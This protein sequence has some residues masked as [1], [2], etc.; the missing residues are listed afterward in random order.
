MHKRVDDESRLRRAVRVAK[1][2]TAALLIGTMIMTAAPS[3]AFAR[4]DDSMVEKQVPKEEGKARIW[5]DKKMEVDAAKKAYNNA[6]DIIK[7]L[8]NKEAR[9]DE[10]ERAAMKL[11]SNLK[12][13][14][15]GK[16]NKRIDELE[17]NANVD[18]KNRL[19]LIRYIANAI[20]YDKLYDNTT[21]DGKL[22][23]SD[24]IN[25]ENLWELYAYS[26]I[27][28]ILAIYTLKEN[29]NTEYGKMKIERAIV[30]NDVDLLEKKLNDPKKNEYLLGESGDT[31]AEKALVFLGDVYTE[32]FGRVLNPGAATKKFYNSLNRIQSLYIP[33]LQNLS[34]PK[35]PHIN[36]VE[37]GNS[38]EMFAFIKAIIGE[39]NNA[40]EYYNKNIVDVLNK[41]PNGEKIDYKIIY[42]KKNNGKIE[43]WFKPEALFTPEGW[44]LYMSYL[45]QSIDRRKLDMSAQELMKNVLDRAVK[46]GMKEL[47]TWLDENKDLLT[48]AQID[49]LRAAGQAAHNVAEAF[50]KAVMSAYRGAITDV[51]VSY[52]ILENGTIVFK[53]GGGAEYMLSDK[54]NHQTTLKVFTEFDYN[55]SQKSGVVVRLEGVLD[56]SNPTKTSTIVFE[57]NA[58]QRVTKW[59]ALES[60]LN[61]PWTLNASSIYGSIGT[62]YYLLGDKLAFNLGGYY[63]RTHLNIVNILNDINIS[64]GFANMLGITINPDVYEV[65]G[66][67]GVNLPITKGVNLNIRGSIGERNYIGKNLNVGLRADVTL[68][69]VSNS[70]VNVT[71]GAFYNQ[72]YNQVW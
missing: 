27:V 6:Y 40:Q 37:I 9:G 61:V 25:A 64:G 63:S 30:F 13:W 22:E 1:R 33:Q 50:K 14:N 15:N 60:N 18:E 69:N 46:K 70:G 47:D 26:Y 55:W 54:S 45:N 59:F 67:A 3:I 29:N 42:F 16:I 23:K 24:S 48:D 20:N 19:E 31:L 65:G 21:S 66:Y 34:L 58:E 7:T 39:N 43:W 44:N 38:D 68:Q 4:E 51:S 2:F 10:R 62:K 71:I 53:V 56:P 36:D 8:E 72:Y 49:T 12:I 28:S 5:S 41:A 17:K 35:V 57:V 32:M 52:N 11:G